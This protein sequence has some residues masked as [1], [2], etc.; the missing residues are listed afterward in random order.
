MCVLTVSHIYIIF[1]CYSFISNVTNKVVHA[2]QCM[3][4]VPVIIAFKLRTL[5]PQWSWATVDF[6]TILRER[7]YSRE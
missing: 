7:K 5:G 2:V 6:S 4:V 3:G 1:I